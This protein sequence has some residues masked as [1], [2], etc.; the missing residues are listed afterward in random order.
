MHL[1]Q[2]AVRGET[3]FLHGDTAAVVTTC[4]LTIARMILYHLLI[5]VVPYI[6]RHY[7]YIGN[8]YW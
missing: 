8:V 1:G 7:R 2:F 5:H 6:E 3:D 4:V